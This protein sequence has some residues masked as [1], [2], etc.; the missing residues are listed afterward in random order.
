MA[1]K[2]DPKQIPGAG[3][4]PEPTR[5]EG[6]KVRAIEIGYY[7]HKRRRV[8]DVFVIDGATH[9][10]DVLAPDGKSVRF[11]K[12]DVKDFSPRWM[13]RVDPRT[14][15]KETSA[16]EALKKVH[17]AIHGERPTGDRN[18]IG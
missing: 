12:G 4:I 13:E 8:D 6:I 14:P 7:D 10:E 5:V 3:R 11:K 18:V 9:P 15:E 16:P 2:S 17:E 1:K